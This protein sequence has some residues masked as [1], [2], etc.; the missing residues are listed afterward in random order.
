M[1]YDTET[2]ALHWLKERKNV[3]LDWPVNKTEPGRVD[4]ILAL[5]ATAGEDGGE[6]RPRSKVNEERNRKRL[7]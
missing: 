1:K 2:K 4:E 6:G 7:K 3:L 5:Y